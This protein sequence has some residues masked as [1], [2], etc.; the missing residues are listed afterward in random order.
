[1]RANDFDSPSGHEVRPIN[2]LFQSHDYI[3]PVVS[4]IVV[5]VFV[6]R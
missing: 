2:D 5:H 6:F 3:R 4:L 1:M